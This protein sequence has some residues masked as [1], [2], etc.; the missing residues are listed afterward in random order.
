MLPCIV[1]FLNPEFS[2]SWPKP[3]EAKT[4]YPPLIVSA[5]VPSSQ[6]AFMF[7]GSASQAAASAPALGPHLLSGLPRK[8]AYAPNL[9]CA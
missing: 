6:V 5:Q 9:R 8:S 3:G 4:M 7:A 1:P 2:P